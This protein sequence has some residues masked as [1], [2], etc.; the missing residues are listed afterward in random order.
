MSPNLE[1]RAHYVLTMTD[2]RGRFI[3]RE[4]FRTLAD[5]ERYASYHGYRH[6]IETIWW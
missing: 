4:A 6:L 1:Y 3:G 2:S 5:A